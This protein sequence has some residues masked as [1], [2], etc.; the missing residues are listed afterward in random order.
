MPA[1]L[2]IVGEGSLD[3]L[4]RMAAR[5]AY[6]GR[7]LR[8]AR[9]APRVLFGELHAEAGELD[10]DA[11]C[12]LDADGPLYP[13][14]PRDVRPFDEACAGDRVRLAADLRRRGVAALDQLTGAYALAHWDETGSAVLL[15][16]DALG[17]K[18]IHV[19]EL[20]GRVAFASDYKALLALE[21]C[22]AELDRDALQTYLAQF[23]APPGRSFLKGIRPLSQ[24]ARCRIRDGHATLEHRRP[25][26]RVS[27]M[28]SF[29]AAARTLRARLEFAV[30]SH[31]AGVESAGVLLS[32]GFDAT[33]LVAL[34]RHVRPDVGLASYTIGHGPED[35]DILGARAVA[36]HFG[37][38]HRETVFDLS[39]LAE[40]LPRVVW[41]MEDLSG[42]DESLLQSTITE[43]AAARHR[44]V[45]SGYGADALFA[46]MPRHRLLWLRDH[47]P[48]PMR[49]ALCELYLYTQYRRVPDSW[50]G[51]KLVARAFNGDVVLPPRIRDA[52]TIGAEGRCLDLRSYRQAHKAPTAGFQHDEPMLVAHG[53]SLA[54]PFLDPAVAQC[55][56]ASP[57]RHHIGLRVQKRLLRAAVADLLP[58]SMRGM[59]KTIQRFRHDRAHTLAFEPLFRELD[60]ARS[61][62]DRGL[63]AAD[64]V[65]SLFEPR[66]DGALSPER[67]HALWALVS[68]ELWMRLFLDRRGQGLPE[69]LRRAS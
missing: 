1:V 58:P 65:A 67:M 16:T 33:A 12:C 9:P 18:T 61:L 6:R 5:M 38:E 10:A 64:G 53:A 66:P 48:P 60:L 13:R 44:V 25:P 69:P 35:P 31:L 57:S 17:F 29:S 47:A 39:R 2:G 50:L 56:L 3:E 49:G 19:V 63:V 27:T 21:D 28:R 30:V 14:G 51:R 41:R 37:C 7:E 20:P 32:G 24:A 45:L 8:V 46:G 68:A 52:R 59:R 36:A 40:D 43:I 4:R 54:M 55:A 22:P 34:V 23:S 62:A 11:T 42:R 26:S 15:A